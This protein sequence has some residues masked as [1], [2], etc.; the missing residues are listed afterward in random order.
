[1]VPKGQSW[2][3]DNCL[4]SRQRLIFKPNFCRLFVAHLHFFLKYC[5]TVDRF[6]K[7]FACVC[8]KYFI[9]IVQFTTNKQSMSIMMTVND[10]RRCFL[11]QSF[12]KI[13]ELEMTEWKSLSK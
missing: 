5:N 13:T 6:L 2:A 10:Y 9:D 1:M 8:E 11:N 7:L 4:A 3:R 12:D